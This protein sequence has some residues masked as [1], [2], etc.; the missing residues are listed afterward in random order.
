MPVVHPS[1]T[2]KG[3]T[4]IEM[5]VTVAVV[6]IL[7]TVA[8]PSFNESIAR[9]RIVSE[10][11]GFIAAASLARSEAIRRNLTTGVCASNNASTCGGTWANGWI[12]WVDADQDGIPDA[13]EALRTSAFS[14]Q[15][16][17]TG[18][19]VDIRFNRRGRRVLPVA[20]VV[21][22]AL[23]PTQCVAGQARTIS[24]NATGAVSVATT[25]CS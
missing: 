15:D 4:L 11:N 6:A 12:V 23:Q 8:L 5:V 2:A 3:F 21:Q 14:A 9:N 7:L 10:V 19:T 25:A 16:T 13:G 17:V 18:V 22:I 24:M 20:G 1:A